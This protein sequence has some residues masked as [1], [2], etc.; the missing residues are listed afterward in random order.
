[1]NRVSK[2]VGL[3][4]L[5]LLVSCQR[6]EGPTPEL[7]GNAAGGAVLDKTQ[8]YWN[9]EVEVSFPELSD[10]TLSG[11]PIIVEQK[12][13]SSKVRS[14][15]TISFVVS[16]DIP[17]GRRTFYFWTNT[18]DGALRIYNA[19]L[20]ILGARTEPSISLDKQSAAFG[21]EVTVTLENLLAARASLTFGGV[22]IS[23]VSAVGSKQLRFTLPTNLASGTRTLQVTSAGKT[24]ST[25]FEVLDPSDFIPENTSSPEFTALVV[26]NT[27][28]ARIR[29]DL[30]ELSE[31]L[32]LSKDLQLI[33][34][35]NLT[36]STT[37]M[38]SQ[39][40]I[41]ISAPDRTQFGAVKER[42]QGDFTY[43]S[44][45][46]PTG[47]WSGG[48]TQATD[49]AA[50][51]GLANARRR[52]LDGRGTTIAVLDTGITPITDLT[53]RISSS[54]DATG[55]EDA[56]DAEAHG[57]PVAL[58]AAGTQAG[59]ASK[60]S[61]A[62]VRV[63][64]ADGECRLDHIVKGMCA[65]IENP[66]INKKKLIFNLSLG[67]KYTSNIV[68]GILEDVTEQGALVAVAAGNDAQDG[69]PRQYPA[70]YAQE[71]AG[72]VAVGA[73]SAGETTPT[74][75][76][77]INDSPANPWDTTSGKA[78]TWTVKKTRVEAGKTY[79]LVGNTN[80]GAPIKEALITE[81][82]SLLCVSKQKTVAE[83]AFVS[84][85][86]STNNTSRH[87]AG[88]RA[89]LTPPV[90]GSSLTSLA[91]ADA[92]C[93]VEAGKLGLRGFEMA[94]FHDKDPANR[95]GWKYW[96]PV[97][98][99]NDVRAA[100]FSTRGDYV[101]IAAPGDGLNVDNT[102]TALSGTS[103][104]T[105]LVSGAMALWRQKYPA[106]TPA[107]IEQAMKESAK[108][109]PGQDPEAVGAGMLDLSGSF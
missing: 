56:S 60:A 50:T 100:P 10:E 43:I 62:N 103:Y 59:I 89:L 55:G 69:S 86:P 88:R 109:L 2:L 34:Y 97:P 70:A 98:L 49:Y 22:P 37:G 12:T 32:N 106:W 54:F 19:E 3:C 18:T 85:E 27:S 31:E 40:Q 102:Y 94:E 76:V 104:A 71:I 90:V 84:R 57:T 87:W 91:V 33:A 11:V 107:Q 25:L 1:M 51:L 63:C 80:G 58:L 105:P 66:R 61:V 9:E 65:V 23:K 46:D 64:G 4:L 15:N 26:R 81:A 44:D 95:I 99:V 45:I 35:E 17:A 6:G 42:L 47:S 14:R 41:R 30:A 68:K 78:M 38:C 21:E 48:R 73:L 29:S 74:F 92:M 16:P 28:E 72:V 39:A 53:N 36:T 79:Q 82:R 93:E 96:L 5:V 52:G 24:A 101:E 77:S 7:E 75:W 108:V 13:Y 67:G 8:A 20:E 83:P